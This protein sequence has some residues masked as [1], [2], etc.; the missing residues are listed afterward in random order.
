L[1]QSIVQR[2]LRNASIIVSRCARGG[3]DIISFF[4]NGSTPFGQLEEGDDYSR[5]QVKE[6]WRAGGMT[7]GS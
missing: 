4:T 2:I 1:L 3:I 6:E 7:M 5:R